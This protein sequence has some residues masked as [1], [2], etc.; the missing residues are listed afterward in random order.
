MGVLVDATVLEVEPENLG[1][2]DAS[3]NGVDEVI[4]ELLVAT[5]RRD[6]R[7]DAQ[8]LISARSIVLDGVVEQSRQ[9][10]RE[11]C[12]DRELAFGDQQPRGGLRPRCDIQ[13]VVEIVV[14][15]PT[16]K[17]PAG[18]EAVGQSE[19]LLMLDA[20]W[21]ASSMRAPRCPRR[22]TP[23]AI[24]SP[25][26]GCLSGPGVSVQFRTDPPRVSVICVGG[27]PDRL[28]RPMAFAPSTPASTASVA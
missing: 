26:T 18:P 23:G 17:Q 22:S 12:S 20:L 25:R 4:I 9:A 16:P 2:I 13:A 19:L 5:Q 28:S 15:D 24:N 7:F 27:P 8:I 6:R 11:R 14:G 3:P 21:P 10:S 1:D